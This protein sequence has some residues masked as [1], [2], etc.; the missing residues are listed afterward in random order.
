[1]LISCLRTLTLVVKDS[2]KSQNGRDHI[3][4]RF[5]CLLTEGSG[6]G[7]VQIITDPGPDPRSPKA[8][9]S[10]GSGTLLAR[11]RFFAVLYWTEH[12]LWLFVL[13]VYKVGLPAEA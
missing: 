12:F 13:Y 7:P 4:S 3:L 6:A 1:L 10:F 11:Q 2:D 9:R 8:Y 5:F